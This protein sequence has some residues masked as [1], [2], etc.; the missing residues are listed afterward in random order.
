MS[1]QLLLSCSD[2]LDGRRPDPHFLPETRAARDLGASVGLVDHD[3]LLAG[4]PGDAV[5]RVPADAGPAW[6]RGWMIPANRYAALETALAARGTPLRITAGQ[7]R[8]AHELPSWY[9]PFADVTPRSRWIA[10]EPCQPVP[11]ADLGALADDLLA[12]GA[13]GAIV[14]DY[15]KSAKH[16]WATACHVPDLADRENLERI[17]AAFVAEQD[18]SLAGGIVLRAYEDFTGPDDAPAPQ[19][20]VW[21]LDGRPVLVTA[22]PDN[23]RAAVAP[24]LTGLARRVQALPARFLTTDLVLRRDRVWR[25]VEVGDGQVS[26]LPAGSDPSALVT[27]LL[28]ARHPD[29]AA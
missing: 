18:E 21:W 11:A 2:P 22:H 25:V 14:K 8:S 20:R 1:T 16:R 7:Y 24:D 6:Y 26:G 12:N 28:G 5:R 19:S 15:V 13:T 9:G 17:V 4:Y 29:P 27:V 10:H 23:P 3:A